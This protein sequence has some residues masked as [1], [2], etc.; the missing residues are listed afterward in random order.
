MQWKPHGAKLS[1][2]DTSQ[3]AEEVEEHLLAKPCQYHT[4][5]GPV[6]T[7]AA[8]GAALQGDEIRS[9]AISKQEQKEKPTSNTKQ[10]IG[11]HEASLK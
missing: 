10:N 11:L 9:L 3:K 1:L 8:L 4:S 7:P 2:N 5:R 6:S